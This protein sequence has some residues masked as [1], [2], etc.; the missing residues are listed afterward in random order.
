VPVIS[1]AIST[2]TISLAIVALVALYLLPTLVALARRIPG[3]AAIAVINILLG[4][5]FIGWVIALAL[6]VRSVPPA[7][8]AVQVVQHFPPP[9]AAAGPLPDAGWSGPPGAP[10]PDRDGAAPPLILPPRPPV[11]GRDP[12]QPG[13][14]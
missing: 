9:P 5:S 12:A 11:V 7:V 1:S 4:W 6:A 10:P 13:Q 2:L 8:P 3:V 14:P